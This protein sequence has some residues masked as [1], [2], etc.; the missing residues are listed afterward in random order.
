MS[1]VAEGMKFILIVVDVVAAFI[2]VVSCLVN[3]DLQL[4]KSLI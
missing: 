1:P 2:T 3:R 4:V